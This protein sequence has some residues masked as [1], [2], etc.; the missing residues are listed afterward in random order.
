MPKKKQLD[1]EILENDGHGGIKLIR[2]KDI[3]YLKFPRQI[4]RAV[5][6]QDGKLLSIGLAANTGE[7]SWEKETLE[8]S[9]DIWRK[10]CKDAKN[11]EKG[12]ETIKANYASYNYKNAFKI[13]GD[14]RD[15]CPSLYEICYQWFHKHKRLKLIPKNKQAMEKTT[16]LIYQARLKELKKCPQ[17]LYNLK[18]IKEWL[19]A[20]AER[21]P[22]TANG[23]FSIIKNSLKWAKNEELVPSSVSIEF[24][25]WNEAIQKASEPKAPSWAHEKGYVNTSREYLAFPLKDMELILQTIKE[26]AWGKT[27]T[28]YF[29]NYAKLKFL[30]GCRSGEGMALR[31]QHFDENQKN[32]DMGIFG[33]LRIE[34]SFSVIL[35]DEKSIKNHKP[36]KIACNKELASFLLEIRPESYSSSD[37]IIEP[38]LEGKERALFLHYFSNCWAGHYGGKSK[39]AI[40][41]KYEGF[42]EKLLDENKLTNR[43]YR[44]PY[45]TRHT[46][47]T[48]QLNAGVP[49]GVVAEWAGD[50]PNTIAAKYMGTD[51]LKA[52]APLFSTYPEPALNPTFTAPAAQSDSALQAVIDYLKSELASQKKLNAGLQERLDEVHQTLL[53]IS[54]QSV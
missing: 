4:A 46:F 42:M 53:K 29:F 49:L 26:L 8:R 32:E 20:T 14:D 16:A 11:P 7:A 25:G 21:A 33:I 37:Y 13:I 1:Y 48:A 40:V 9:I 22:G 6:N 51:N 47:I 30:T 38:N 45:A 5:W 36:H 41:Y 27:P 43:V 12:Y 28:G 10:A 35:K 39:G 3:Y 31:W 52:P 18:I 19:I 2:K 24:E 15:I 34:R 54:G 17:D 50:E 23:L 44:S